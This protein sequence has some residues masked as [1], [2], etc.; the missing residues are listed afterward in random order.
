MEEDKKLKELIQ[1]LKE[2][3]KSSLALI[4]SGARLLKARA[5][6]DSNKEQ[7]TAWYNR[8]SWAKNNCY[9]TASK[10]QEN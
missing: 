10:L 7:K 6:L 4:D 3:D 9:R 8:S 5:E 2:L 1:I